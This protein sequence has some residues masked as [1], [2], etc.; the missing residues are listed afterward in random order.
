M[1]TMIGG[2]G[3]A[4]GGIS[5]LGGLF[6]GGQN[7]AQNVRLPQGFQMPGMNQ[8]AGGAM[9]GIGSL[10]NY[11][12]DIYPGYQSTYGNFYQ[13]NPFMGSALQDVQGAARAGQGVGQNQINAGNMLSQGGAS[14]IP[15]TTSLLQAGF[16]PQQSL[17]NRTQ[18]QLQEQT[19][20]GLAARGLDMSPYGAGVENKAMSDFNI[21]WQNNLLNRMTQGAQGAGGLLGAAGGAMQTGAGLGQQGYGTLTDAAT[22]PYRTM[23]G[24]G[25]D[26][27]SGLG[28][29]QGAGQAASQIP[30][31]QIQDYLAY[32]GVGNQAG[33]VG[34][35]LAQVGLNQANMGFNQGQV[36]GQNLGSSLSGLGRSLNTMYGRPQTGWGGG[37]GTG[38]GSSAYGWG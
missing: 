5:A 32:L 37:G 26:Q 30:Q 2:I 15:Y 23:I 9:G 11:A 20:A 21:D 19:R 38:W 3:S 6:G 31:Q 35:Q 25:S 16:D 13:G 29:L 7:N 34:N 28:Q 10:P 14:M 18:Q 8:A 4:L 1:G 24:M 33:Q 22:L 27:F 36:L 17:Y 12:A